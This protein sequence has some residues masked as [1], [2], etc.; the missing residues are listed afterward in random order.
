[1]KTVFKGHQL[2]AL[3]AFLRDD[4]VAARQLQ[5]G[6]VGLGAAVAKEHPAAEGPPRQRVGKTDLVLQVVK[7][8]SVNQLARLRG[9]HVG[10]ARIAVAHHAHRDPRGH[11]KV[12]AAGQVPEQTPFA[13]VEHHRRLPIV[14][15]QEALRR[16]HHFVLHGHG[17]HFI[18]TLWPTR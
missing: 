15:H 2:D 9:D 3:G 4:L 18:R 7:V 13:T 16:L 17:A 10:Q 14:V 12:T 6:F 11:I 5:R 1:V 8:R